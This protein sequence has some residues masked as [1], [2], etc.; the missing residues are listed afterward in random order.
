VAVA[1]QQY[2]EEVQVGSAKRNLGSRKE[3]ALAYNKYSKY[4]IK[5]EFA[6]KRILALKTNLYRLG[7]SIHN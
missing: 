7:S 1:W 3:Y 5:S 2:R 6:E 4:L